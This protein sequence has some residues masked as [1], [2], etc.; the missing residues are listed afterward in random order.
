MVDVNENEPFPSPSGSDDEGQRFYLKRL[1][2]WADN[3]NLK[4]YLL[5]TNTRNINMTH[6]VL[7]DNIQ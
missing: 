6:K 1:M 4:V 3:L 7:Y 2:G 5:L